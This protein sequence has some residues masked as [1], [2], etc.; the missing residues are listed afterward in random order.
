MNQRRVK[1]SIGLILLGGIITIGGLAFEGNWPK[2]LRVSIAIGVYSGL[3]FLL[4]RRYAS[5]YMAL[6]PFLLAAAAAEIASG[7]LRPD[8]V[9]RIEMPTVAAASLLGVVHWAGLYASEFLRSSIIAR[10]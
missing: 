1:F 3:L 2:A 5:G 4:I 9:H 7:W 8:A 6:W 10:K